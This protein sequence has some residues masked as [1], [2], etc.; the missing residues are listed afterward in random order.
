LPTQQRDKR[1]AKKTGIWAGRHK[2]VRLDDFPFVDVQL[3]QFDLRLV[4][5]TLGYGKFL[6]STINIFSFLIFSVF[7]SVSQYA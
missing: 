1:T 3:A 7:G 4:T 5:H 2:I 6:I